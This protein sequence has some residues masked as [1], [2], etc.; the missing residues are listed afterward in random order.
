MFDET[1]LSEQIVAFDLEGTLTAA[2]TWRGM[3]DYLGVNGRSAQFRRFFVRHLPQ[4]I[5][6]RLGLL[7]NVPAFKEQWVLGIL[8]L[9]ADMS[10]AQIE[11]MAAYVAETVL[12]PSR[13][14]AVVAELEGHR[15]NGRSVIIVSGM[16]E[17]ILARI[18]GKLGVQALGTPLL[19]AGDRFTGRPD[20]AINVGERKVAKLQGLLG[21]GRSLYAAYGDT[22]RD[23]PMLRLSQQPVAVHPDAA[24]RQEAVAQ[25]WRILVA[26]AG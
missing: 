23:I 11:A 10:R 25:G 4:V 26:D 19:F 21:N 16:F 18:A 14:L 1:S 15:E 22:R 12:W 2:E 9:Y 7:R 3:R 6:Y 5:G 13:R 20:G 24:L 17:P 8:D